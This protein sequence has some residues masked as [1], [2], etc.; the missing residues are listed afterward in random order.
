MRNLIEN[1]LK[2]N[3]K[4]YAILA[5]ILLLGLIIGI[6]F[7]N[8]LEIAQKEEINTYLTDFVEELKN[9]NSINYQ[10]LL[11]KS[12]ITN[13]EFITLVVLLNFSIWGGISNFALF[14][15]KGFKLGY[16]I[17]SAIA[18][19]GVGKGML[20]TISLILLTEILKI[21]TTLF[22][23]VLSSKTY[24]EIIYSDRDEK[25]VALIRYLIMLLV[26]VIILLL[27][28]FLQT[29]LNNNIFLMFIKYF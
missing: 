16:S 13:I 6:M 4:S 14:G 12:V 11:K 19:F 8:N 17:S 10:S 23:A 2:E 15:Y 28:S 21:P 9:D 20:F 18:I 3:I 7:V 27:I 24:K 5:L 1:N 25:K 22:I 29:Y 26:S